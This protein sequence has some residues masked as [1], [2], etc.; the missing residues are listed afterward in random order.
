VPVKIAQEAA[1]TREHL[2]D[3]QHLHARCRRVTPQGRRSGRRP[4]VWRDG[5][6]WT[7]VV[8]DR[9]SAAA[10]KCCRSLE[11]EFGGAARI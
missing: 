6:F 2:D 1:R 7:E 9:G 11:L 3:P 8:N 4:V 5:L 10:R